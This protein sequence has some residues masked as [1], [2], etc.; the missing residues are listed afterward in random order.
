MLSLLLVVRPVRLHLGR[1]VAVV[2]LLWTGADIVNAQLCSVDRQPLSSITTLRVS[3][4]TSQRQSP[5]TGDDCFCCSHTVQA[6]T[7]PV[8]MPILAAGEYTA[9]LDL[10]SHFT[11]HDQIYRP[12]QSS[13]RL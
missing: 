12:P 9:Q 7:A 11:I 8:S 6:G 13:A 2:L 10:G 1:I 5:A 3:D 4:A